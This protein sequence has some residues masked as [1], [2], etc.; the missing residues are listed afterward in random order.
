MGILLLL[1]GSC[2]NI[3]EGFFTKKN[4]VRTGGKGGFLFSSII[5]MFA[6]LFFVVMVVLKKGQP[7]FIPEMWIYGI[8]AGIFYCTASFL[9]YVALGCGPFALSMLII[10][11]CLIFTIGYGLLTGEASSFGVLQYI[12]LAF[13]LVSLY[14][15]RGESSGENKVSAKWLVSIV[16]TSV[17]NGFFGIDRRMQQ[18][19]FNG[20]YDYEFMIITL[21]I[22]TVIL[23]VLGLIKDGL[24]NFDGASIGYAVG[25]GLC[26]GGNNCCNLLVNT[27]VIA[28]PLALSAP[29]GSGIRIVLSFLVSCF[30]FKEHFLKRQIAGVA[31][32]GAAIVLLN[33]RL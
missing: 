12:G 8:L 15:T 11:Y 19:R 4:S 1:L 21:G 23:F 14:L 29:L 2:L 7:Q 30:L 17:L 10:S 6:M 32:G 24:P 18:V 3:S 27:G 16:V 22:S 5:S 28:M 25:T 26:N 33:I 9:T 20:E 31:L 13:I